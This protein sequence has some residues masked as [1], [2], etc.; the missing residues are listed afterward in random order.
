[1]YF[2]INIPYR[3]VTFQVRVEQTA[4]EAEDADLGQAARRQALTCQ[5]ET[6]ISHSRNRY[7]LLR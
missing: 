6:E 3:K 2:T 7:F 5:V 4:R 1:M